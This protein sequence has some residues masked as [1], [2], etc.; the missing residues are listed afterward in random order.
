IQIN[1]I[2]VC[3]VMLNWSRSL[4]IR[5][6]RSILLIG[7]PFITVIALRIFLIPVERMPFDSDEAIFLLMARHILDGERPLFFYGEAYGGST[8]SYFTALFYYLFDDSITAARLVQSLEYLIGMLFTYLLARRLLPN[9]RFG[10]LAVLWL[11]A[12]PPLLM[13]TW[14]TPAVLYAVV[15]CLGSII[16]YLGYRLLWEDADRLWRWLVF[17]AI[18]GL[19]FWTFGILVVY[20]MPVFLLFLWKFKWRR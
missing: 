18:C 11:M 16:S 12:L 8:D 14:T 1:L 3:H 15:I 17:G 13:T 10:P 19:A 6:W 9:S 7:A 5:L 20:M 4:N 2:S